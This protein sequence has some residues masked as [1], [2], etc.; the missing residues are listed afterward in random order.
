[1]VKMSFTNNQT[2]FEYAMYMMLGSYFNKTSCKNRLLEKKMRLLYW[3][4]REKNQIQL[5]KLCIRFIEKELIPQ[6]PEDI[7]NHDVEV[8]FCPTQ[9]KG[10]QDIQFHSPEYILRVRAIYRGKDTVIQHQLWHKE[11]TTMVEFQDIDLTKKFV[12]IEETK[13]AAKIPAAK[14]EQNMKKLRIEKRGA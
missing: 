7:W 4:Q 9:Y 8:K 1:M 2:A 12:A 11:A 14:K 3:E 5:E 10:Y 13:Q 6:L